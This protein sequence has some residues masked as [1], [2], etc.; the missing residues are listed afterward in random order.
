MD[1]PTSPFPLRLAAIDVGSNAIRFAAGEFVDATHWL[2]LEVQRV[3]VRLGHGAFLTGSLDERTMAAAI[4]TMATF[5]RS[6]DNLG[7][8]RYRAVATSAV[9]DSRNGPELVD[10]IRRETGIQLETI[11]GTEEARLVWVALRNRVDFGDGLWIATDLGGGSLEISLVS[12]EGIHWSESHTMGTVRLLE[13]LGQVELDPQ[14]FRVLLSE[15]TN[16]LRLPDH[17]QPTELAG[18][19]AT[20]GNIEALADLAGSAVDDAGVSRLSYADLK[21]TASMLAR[22][23][24][25]ERIEQ[26]GLR[27]DRADVILPA[28]VIYGQVARLVGVK[29][30]VVPRVG[31][32]EGVL[33]DLADD[34]TGPAVHASRLEQLAFRGAL[35][36][37]QRFRFDEIH[38]RHVA[39]LSL[40]LF[41]Q[42]QDVHEL[43]EEDRRILLVAAA[44]HDVGQFVSYRKHHKHSLYL[45]YNSDIPGLS[46]HQRILAALVARYH[47]RAEPKDEHFLFDALDPGDRNRVRRM[48]SVL[49]LGDALDREHL[50]RVPSVKARVEGGG[51][52]LEME[53]RGDLLLEHWSLRKKSRMFT[54]VFGLEV[55]PVRTAHAGPKVI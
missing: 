47:R 22:M 27:E 20:G 11:T 13:D 24:V 44:L 26:L 7:V 30:L 31:V 32:R 29:E 37:G 54:S 23:T 45:I 16:T 28:A 21:T 25:D 18:L 38:G 1:R 33:L 4:E 15:Y 8:S 42:L 5:R 19:I 3:P 50:Q 10:R 39:R 52:F 14:N 43:D 53:G 48:A 9:R 36:L 2:E 12:G 6:L 17:V 55:H 51:L 41:D 49:R 46:R 40:S 35:T 34:I